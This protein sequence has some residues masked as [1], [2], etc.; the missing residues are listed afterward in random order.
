MSSGL[1]ADIRFALR[2][3]RKAPAFTLVAIVSL[4]I[5]IGFNTA[6]FAIADALLFRPLPLP[7]IDR[8]V[9]VYTSAT[10]GADSAVARFGTSSYPDYLDLA[11]QNDVFDE[12]IGYS[13]IVGAVSAGDAPRLALG[14]IVTGN[15]FRAI[16]VRAAVGRALEPS[17]DRAILST[18]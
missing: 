1:V 17:D 2:W 13:P 14:E 11:A 3:L 7:A 18:I 16:G 5:G 9:D 8:W 4:A 10:V 12:L 6:L 15:Y